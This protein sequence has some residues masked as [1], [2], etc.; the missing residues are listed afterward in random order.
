MKK[1]K[2]SDNKCVEVA[3]SILEVCEDWKLILCLG[4]DVELCEVGKFMGAL[5]TCRGIC[6]AVLIKL[7]L[8]L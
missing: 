5:F 6:V 7:V 4:I 3:V 1:I 8:N 2:T